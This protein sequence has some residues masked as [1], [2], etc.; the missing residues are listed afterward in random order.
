MPG[1]SPS[2]LVAPLTRRLPLY[3]GGGVLA[4]RFPLRH[5]AALGPRQAWASLPTGDRLLVDRTDLVG[6]TIY[7]TGDFSPEITFAM[8]RLL[9]PGDT[10]LDIG[11]NL[12][13][14]SL[15]MAAAVGVTGRV[16]AFE[17]NPTLAD[18]LQRSLHR[19]PERQVTIHRTALGESEG[20]ATLSVP[21]G[22]A[23]AATLAS[24]PTNNDAS[25][26]TTTVRVPVRTLDAVLAA[27][28]HPPVRAVKLDVEGF[29]P[30]VLAGARRTLCNHP[31]H[32]IV[33]ENNDRSDQPARTSP[34]FAALLEAGYTLHRFVRRVRHPLFER[35]S[36]S[37]LAR[38]AR[39]I[40]H[41]LLALH[42]SGDEQD[43][44]RRLA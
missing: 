38:P 9:S 3:R 5:L 39:S 40:G 44:L 20:E 2:S 31:P 8:T 32:A 4:H 23:G 37:D 35:L 42:P 25:A 1:F 6:R 13:V 27:L 12:G 21:T 30:A 14:V 34:V 28:D 17:P 18:T 15:R 22:N 7:Y 10:A 26:P 29:E 24:Q 41:D 33:F 43:M 36:E 11:A 19:A 16:H